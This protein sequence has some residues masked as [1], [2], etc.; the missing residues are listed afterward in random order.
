MAFKSSLTD[1]KVSISKSKI[2]FKRKAQDYKVD[3]LSKRLS[4][5]KKLKKPA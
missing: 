1:Y 2:E 4:K 5:D 3:N